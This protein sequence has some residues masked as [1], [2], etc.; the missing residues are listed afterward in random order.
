MNSKTWN[1]TKIGFELDDQ[2]VDQER[3]DQIVS[4]LQIEIKRKLEENLLTAQQKTTNDIF[5]LYR[6]D[7]VVL[8]KS[9]VLPG[10]QSWKKFCKINFPDLNRVLSK[11][12]RQYLVDHLYKEGLSQSAIAD[13]LWLDTATISRDL[14]VSTN[15]RHIANA[16]SRTT[17][18]VDGKS[19]HD[20]DELLDMAEQIWELHA[21]GMTVTEIAKTLNSSKSTISEMIKK[22]RANQEREEKEL[23]A[24]VDQV[25]AGREE[26]A[27]RI[28]AVK[29]T[30]EVKLQ[31]KKFDRA[32][33]VISQLSG[34]ARLFVETFEDR[35]LTH[36]Q[37]EKAI[38]ALDAMMGVIAKNFTSAEPDNVIKIN[39]A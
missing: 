21:D 16:T 29:E 13:L 12:T 39:R 5:M 6:D 34:Y 10:K 11:P 28:Q 20:S 26:K 36:D 8:Y 31:A 25:L 7:F 17:V 3:V 24:K 38:A 2:I 37:Y 19:Y 14:G 18:G 33:A 4:K 15:V 35:E 9:I 22:Y 30:E 27:G 1:V 23:T 32:D